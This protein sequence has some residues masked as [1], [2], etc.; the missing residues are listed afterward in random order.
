MTDNTVPT[1]ESD[2]TFGTP[3]VARRG[4]ASI[5][6]RRAEAMVPILKQKP[7]EWA[8]FRSNMT[9]SYASKTATNYRNRYPD[10]EWLTARDAD[11]TYSVWVRFIAES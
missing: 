1:S 5:W 4:P 7:G 8:V 10:L 11:G 2:V 9:A 6:P 3:K